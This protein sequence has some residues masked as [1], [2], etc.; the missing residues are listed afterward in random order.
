MHI[1]FAIGKK[2]D[3]KIY[4][5]DL[6]ETANL[7]VSYC[8]ERQLKKMFKDLQSIDY[9]YKTKDYYFVSKRRCVEWGVDLQMMHTLFKDEPEAGSIRKKTELFKMLTGE[10]LR[11][12][13]L[14]SR[15]Q[16]DFKK[17]FE[18]NTWQDQ[19]M[20]YQFF[21]V[22]DIWDLIK[23]ITKTQGLNLIRILLYGPMVGIH[24]LFTSSL[25]YRNLLEQLVDIHPGVIEELR[26]K[27]G[28]PEP[29]RINSFSS[30][31]II[32]ADFLVFFKK[33]GE[34]EMERL[35]YAGD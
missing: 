11:R 2:S 26:M 7:M 12:E 10:I 4:S 8:E 33:A 34:T 35:Y 30:E 5:I 29:K 24:T 1:P 13:K 14:L 6:S 25:S 20:T 22:D 31:L 32:T 3:G 19:K 9:A 23:G 18:L 21:I 28:V 15:K 17:Y 16:V 27:F